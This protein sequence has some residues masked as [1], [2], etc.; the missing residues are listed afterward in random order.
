MGGGQFLWRAGARRPCASGQEACAPHFMVRFS[1][2]ADRSRASPRAPGAGRNPSSTRRGASRRRADPAF[3]DPRLAPLFDAPDH[4]GGSL[5]AHLDLATGLDARSGLDIGCGP[6]A[7]APGNTGM[8][9]LLLMDL[10]A[11]TGNVAGMSRDRD[12]WASTSRAAHAAQ[13]PNGHL[14]FD[15]RNP[16]RQARREPNRER[17]CRRRQRSVVDWVA[18]WRN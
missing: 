11:M 9:P 5:N 17:S 4:A 8:I 14:L 15:A 2:R 13:R 3:G 7:P 6:C 18:A 12:D 1:V 16:V 10:P